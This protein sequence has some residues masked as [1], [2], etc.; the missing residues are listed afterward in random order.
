MKFPIHLS[1]QKNYFQTFLLF[2]ISCQENK[3]I[4]LSL[5]DSQNSI[6][7]TKLTLID[8]DLFSNVGV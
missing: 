1:I 3:Q 8:D 4:H 6:Q 5:S 2:R 7:H